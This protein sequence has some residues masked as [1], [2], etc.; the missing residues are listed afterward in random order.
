MIS[1]ITFRVVKA[2]S[3]AYSISA[4]AI[5]SNILSSPGCIV[6]CKSGLKEPEKIV[7]NS[8]EGE[9]YLN[10]EVTSCGGACCPIMAVNASTITA[11]KLSILTNGKGLNE[12][13]FFAC[14]L[15]K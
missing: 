14:F 11:N 6:N 8:F 3:A 2:T 5:N 15:Y 12:S 10:V 7:V 9:T 1:K 4:A 13:S